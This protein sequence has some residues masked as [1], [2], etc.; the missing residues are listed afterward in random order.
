MCCQSAIGV[1]AI[2]YTLQTVRSEWILSRINLFKNYTLDVTISAAGKTSL[3]ER[4][5]LKKL[6][7]NIRSGYIFPNYKEQR[8]GGKPWI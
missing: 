3:I 1:V 2:E 5:T 6:Q 7:D 8:Q 4:I